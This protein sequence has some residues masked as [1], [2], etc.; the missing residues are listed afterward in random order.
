MPSQA[1]NLSDFIKT[2][3]HPQGCF[4]VLAE[5][6]RKGFAKQTL[7]ACRPKPYGFGTRLR[8]ILLKTILNRFLNAKC[9]L[10]LRIS[11]I[12]LKQKSTHK[13]AFCFGG[14]GE[15]RTLEPLLTVTR[16]P[17]VRARPTTRH[18]RIGL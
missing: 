8:T 9:P 13:G 11:L 17:I 15:I 4:F 10:R 12:S 1:S 5:M 14:D 7:T 16:F 18:L 3:K 2:K 6:E